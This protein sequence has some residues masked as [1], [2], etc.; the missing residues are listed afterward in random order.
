[1]VSYVKHQYRAESNLRYREKGETY[2][3][4]I[5]LVVQT[6]D[7]EVYCFGVRYFTRQGIQDGGE[8][9]VIDTIVEGDK[10]NVGAREGPEGIESGF[11]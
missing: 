4:P 5:R 3:A 8:R 2:V 10:R 7:P 11:Y 6:A 1:M 9:V